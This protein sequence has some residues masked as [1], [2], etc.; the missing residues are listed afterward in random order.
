M[1]RYFATAGDR[2]GWAIDEDLRLI[3]RSL[4]GVAEETSLGRAQVVHA[5]FWL[6]L[7]MHAGRA[8]ESRFVIAQADNPPFFY[9]TQPEFE[10]GQRV[11]D[12]W[13]ARS[14]EAY[15]QFASLGL[16]S[17]HI[18]Y[19]IDTKLF[20]PIA[21][22]A[23][24]R[25]RLGLPREAYVIGN[26]HRDSEGSDLGQPKL[27]KCPEMLVAVVARLRERGLPVHVLLAGP[28]R[29]WI[30]RALIGRGIPFTFAGAPGIAG[31]DLHANIL[32]RPRLNELYNACDLYLIPS[33]WEGGPQSVMEAAAA[34]V[35][36]LS[37][38]LGVGLDI[39][40]PESIFELPRDAAGRI[41]RDIRDNHLCATLDAQAVRLQRNHT[42]EAMARGLVD[43]YR[44]LHRQPHFMTK[45]AR[46]RGGL[47]DTATDIAWQVRRR[48]R[49]PSLPRAVC[50]E[51]ASGHD[52]FL[53]EAVAN[54][55]ELLRSIGVRESSGAGGISI[56][57]HARASVSSDYVL[58]TNGGMVSGHGIRGRCAIAL[59]AQDAVNFRRDNPGSQVLVCPL[60]FRGEEPPRTPRPVYEGDTSASLAVAR[61][62]AGGGVVVYPAGSAYYFQAFH[63]GVSYG[64]SRRLDEALQIAEEDSGEIAALRHVPDSRRAG[65]FWRKLLAR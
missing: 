64:K 41:E 35:K 29:H 14:V 40:E 3:R 63:A 4:R 31:D 57:G 56:A 49:P 27:Q 19:A 32:P 2:H 61:A 62:L 44:N 17:V 16:P 58:L 10:W 65:A 55:R 6:A 20:F 47:R 60:I 13:V 48:F 45:M 36:I 23:E 43:L 26:F 11:V 24:L 7:S 15:G 54:L 9:L 50:I 8:L 28:R 42:A 1:I 21:E 25:A 5:P 46:P 34:R 38:P 33:R 18:P 53:D 59:S 51:H 30:R 52:P 37:T 39:L 12:L 22:R